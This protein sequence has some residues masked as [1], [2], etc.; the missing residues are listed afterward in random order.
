MQA[1]LDDDEVIRQLVLPAFDLTGATV[2]P[3]GAGLINRTYL[4]E[5]GG[6]RLVLQW[7]SP[8]FPPEIHDNIAAVTRRLAEAGLTTPRLLD[9]R[10]G[11]PC[12]QSPEHG[13]WRIMTY[14]A[15]S[16]FDVVTSAAQA[17][18]AGN[19]VARFH[20]AL[21]GLD[22]RFAGLRSGVHDTP[23]HL[24]RLRHAVEEHRTHR[25]HVRVA[26]LGAE[27]LEAARAL[28]A[29][30]DL[31]LRVCHGDLKFNNFVFAGPEPPASE[32]ALCLIDLDT[33]GPMGLAYE[34]GDAWRS[35]CNRAGEDATEA[36][37][38][39]E[40]FRAS[41]DGYRTGLGR[42]LSRDEKLALLHGPEWISLEL[43]AR[44]AADALNESYFGWNR[45][46]YPGRGEHN[47][48]RARGQ[49]SLHRSFVSTGPDRAREL[50]C[51]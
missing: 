1:P 50:G 34:L 23:R 25:L 20:A 10:H 29:L 18:S 47:L 11:G 6:A 17:R 15:G 21:D 46:R 19:L 48:V 3:L 41:L 8:I 32:R 16:S 22:H 35:W 27:I 30:P 51:P 5:L 44:F 31:P 49:L 43:A 37:L 38:D 39:L 42:A 36:V 14:V 9:A 12:L 26:P 45:E 4:V 28:P 40:A 2:R 7:V 33:V 13:T 24:E